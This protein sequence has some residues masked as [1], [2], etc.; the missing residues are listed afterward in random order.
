MTTMTKL[1]KTAIALGGCISFLAVLFFSCEKIPEYCG[2][3]HSLNPA[4]QFCFGGETYDKCAGEVYD[5]ANQECDD[6][7][8]KDRCPGSNVFFNPVTEFCFDGEKY[9]KCVGEEFNPG[10]QIC[11]DNILKTRCGSG[12]SY[13]SPE[14]EFCVGSTVHPK[15][16]GAEYNPANQICVDNNTIRTICE[17]G[18]TVP[19]GTPCD[20]YILTTT[21]APANGGTIDRNPNALNYAPGTL[22]G[23][24]AT[25]VDGYTF[26]G[27][28]GASTSTTPTIVVTM[29]DDR[30]L[31]AIFA[32][33]SLPDGPYTLMTTVIPYSGSGTILLNPPNSAGLPAGT[34]TLGTQVTVTATAAPHYRF[35]DW[36][37]ASSSTLSDAT[38]IMDGNK[39]LIA[40]FEPITY[41]LTTDVNHVGGGSVERIP[42]LTSYNVGAQVNMTATESS[43]FRFVDW[44]VISGTATLS[45]TDSRTTTVSMLSDAAVRANFVRIFTL[46]VNP[47]TGG[48]ATGGGTFDDG[49]NAPITATPNT[50]YRFNGWTPATG[51]GI[52]NPSDTSTTVLMT[53]NKIVTANFQQITYTLTINRSPTTGGTVTPV[54]D[55]SHPAGTPISI[56][57]TPAQNHTF[58]NWTVTGSGA[59]I[60]N[61]NSAMT[62]VA[63]TANATIT[64]NFRI[65]P[66]N[67]NISYGT[68]TDSRDQINY[69]T[70]K[71]GTQTWMAE[72]LNFDTTGSRCYGDPT[73]G[74]RQNTCGT[75]GRLYDWVTA[76]GLPS[77]CNSTT[78]NTMISVKH[79]GIC[80]AG[81]HVPSY[82]GWDTLINYVGGQQVAGKIL[83]ATSVWEHGMTTTHV[84]TDEYGFS[85]LPGGEGN[86]GN[87]FSVGYYGN[88]WYATEHN[89]GSAREQ[90]IS[91]YHSFVSRGTN[92]KEYLFSLR[93]LRDD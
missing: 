24:T 54:T 30:S 40:N 20:G 48:T 34:Y 78:C 41:T 31:V 90:Y 28:S 17:G 35:I 43:G 22:I 21:A 87:F 25:P 61:A 3:G 62:T 5:P 82:A 81:W 67:P 2:D 63:L 37:G 80:P 77:S 1:K 68:F 32:P 7:V 83:K 74:D 64:A 76:M 79:R 53:A 93:C 8:L 14:E 70:V 44:T 85:A 69:R 46:T 84:G 27:W 56:T 71:I 38:I 73:G 92:S 65:D 36:A 57:A 26:S 6:N 89:A 9:G 59:T 11:E 45:S 29:D 88:W 23:V 19:I 55:D 75:Y 72:N 33:I 4:T 52:A 12:S 13:F 39:M 42:S 50:G 18:R 58:T 16:D 86:G 60:D 47:G 15:C 49:T 91:S 51:A 66:F 10:N